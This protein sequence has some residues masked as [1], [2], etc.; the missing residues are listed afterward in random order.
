[1]IST[2][3]ARRAAQLGRHRIEPR[4]VAGDEHE[5]VPAR[6]QLPRELGADAGRAPGDQSGSHGRYDT[7]Q[8]STVPASGGV[9]PTSYDRAARITILDD[10]SRRDR[11]ERPTDGVARRRRL[12]RARVR[13]H[14]AGQP[15]R[16]ARPRRDRRRPGSAADAIR[17]LR[18]LRDLERST[19]Q[20]MRN[21]LVT[22]THK[23]ARVT[24][25]L[26]TW[27]FEKF[28]IA[29]ALDAVLEATG[30]DLHSSAPAGGAAHRRARAR[31]SAA[32]RS[33]APS[34]GNID[35]P[36]IVAAHVTTGL[37]DEWIT[38]AAYRRLGELAERA[39]RRSST[40]IIGIKDRHIA[41]PRRRGAAPPRR[42]RRARASSPA[43]S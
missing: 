40:L 11:V 39:A 27:A 22:A 20:R 21:L 16:R 9:A 34:Q 1:M 24:A 18:L 28:W 7:V 31:A 37:V 25:F 42:A 35:G 17:L 2:V 14:R 32:A 12:R 41:L 30:D 29:D 33:R 36:Q 43:A 4:G 6:G 26:T 10:S 3:A 19:M 13:A 15:P 38:Q 8:R 23:D 5:V